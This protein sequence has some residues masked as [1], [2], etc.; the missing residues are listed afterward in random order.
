MDRAKDQKRRTIEETLNRLYLIKKSAPKAGY[1]ALLIIYLATSA[2]TSATASS[3]TE[4]TVAGYTVPIYIFAGVLSS[5]ANI[6]I[7][8]MAVFY[9]TLGVITSLVLIAIQLPMI[10][11]GIVVRHNITSLPGVFGDVLAI[12]AV[13]FIYFN[14]RKMSEYQRVLRDQAVTDMLTGLPNWFACTELIDELVRREER[15]AVCSIDFNG[16]KSIND[17]MGF[18]AG[19]RVLIE[20]SNKWKSI[21]DSGDSGT[22]DFISRLNGDEFSLVI[23]E[24]ESEEEVLHTIRKYDA[25][26]NETIDAMGYDFYLSASFGYA[27]YPDDA[28]D[29][30]SVISY[31][32]IAMHEIKRANSGEHIEK[33]TPEILKKEH[34]FEMEMKLRAAIDDDRVFFMLQPQ[35]DMTHKLRGFEALARIRNE[36]GEIIPPGLFIP[37]AEKVG[38]I[39]KIDSIVFRKSAA[40][41]GDLIKRYDLDVTLSINISVRHLMKK[42]FLDDMRKQLEESGL[43]SGHLEVE[44]TE[45]VMIE[46]LEK[47]MGYIHELRNMGVQIAIDDFGTG[48][49]SLSYLNS[50][51]ANLLKI[52]KTFIDGVSSSDKAKQYVAAIISLGHIMGYEVISEGVEE[53]DQLEIL[54]E[55]GCDYIQG[56]I[57]GKPLPTEEVEKLVSEG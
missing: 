48:Y 3:A 14:N 17:S 54:R 37:V 22:M 32:D 20:I 25:A 5:L 13:L 33:F 6:C 45:S 42:D 40:F 27:I 7:I 29:M 9:D 30:D 43:P 36:A 46:S 12:I 4:V 2:A 57:W 39:D 1:W 49:S 26:V 34:T 23:R 21:A 41:V 50:I 51:P 44:I 8:L 38:L 11:S 19:N 10:I 24:F 16:F 55:I 56:F 31:S 53:D 15:F 52:D 35:Y 28:Q 18:E 47:A